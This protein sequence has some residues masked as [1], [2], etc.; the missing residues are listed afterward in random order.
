MYVYV[1]MHFYLCH[2]R[3]VDQRGNM[4]CKTSTAHLQLAIC[5]HWTEPVHSPWTGLWTL[6]YGLGQ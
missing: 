2:C 4:V 3:Q 6:D 5:K 1:F